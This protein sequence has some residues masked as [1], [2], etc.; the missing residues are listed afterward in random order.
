M[1]TVPVRA[2]GWRMEPPVSVA[3]APR[4]RLAATA[5]EDP[6][7]EPPD[8]FRV[9]CDA[10]LILTAP[11]RDDGAEG[12]GLVGRTHCEFVVVELA[13]HDGAG[14]PEIGTDGRFIG[15]YEV[16]EDLRACGG[17]DALGAEEVLVAERIP[18]RGRTS[19]LARR[20]SEAFA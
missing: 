13:E 6:P 20:A 2:A 9:R 7:D 1:P 15:G 12:A 11:G 19:P 10:V 18:S 4:H 17:A 3:V 14:I 5:A 8:E 16:A